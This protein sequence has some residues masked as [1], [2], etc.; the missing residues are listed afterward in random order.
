VAASGQL[1]VAD[2]YTVNPD[3]NDFDGAVF[4]INPQTRQQT[5]IARGYGNIVNPCGLTIVP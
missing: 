3:T 2:P 4:A 5:L 1:V